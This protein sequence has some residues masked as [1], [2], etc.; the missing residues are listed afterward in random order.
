MASEDTTNSRRPATTRRFLSDESLA[1]VPAFHTPL[2]PRQYAEHISSYASRSSTQSLYPGTNFESLASFLLRAYRRHPSETLVSS[3]KTPVS[4]DHPFV[5][6][7]NLQHG[8]PGRKREFTTTQELIDYETPPIRESESANLL[9]LRGYPSAEWLN[10]LGS[11]FTIDPEFFRR[12]L[13]FQKSAASSPDLS[14]PAL[15]SAA[16]IMTRLRANTVAFR[17]DN[18][19]VPARRFQDDLDNLR[20]E[21]KQS[22]LNYLETLRHG[23]DIDVRMGESVVR[24]FCVL[25]RQYTIIE[26]D[27]SIY[28]EQLERGFFAVIWLDPS[29]DLFES[30]K[31]PWNS[32]SLRSPRWSVEY[33]PIIQPKPFSALRHPSLLPNTASQSEVRIPQS[34]A[35]LPLEYTR[36]LDTAL[37]G[38]DRFFVLGNIFYFAASSELLALNIIETSLSQEL[39]PDAILDQ[40]RPSIS[41]LLHTK[42]ILDRHISRLRENIAF[43]RKLQDVAPMH[44]VPPGRHD[45]TDR[46]ALVMSQAFESLL[47]RAQS[48]AGKC[49]RGMDIINTQASIRE[50]S[51]GI[52]QAEDMTRLTKLALPFIPLSLTTSFFGMNF[53]ELGS[54]ST[55]SIWVWLVT[56]AAVLMGTFTFLL[57]GQINVK[58][59]LLIL[60][61]KYQR[62]RDKFSV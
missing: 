39:E 24:E 44:L 32:G 13:D 3:S 29:K 58:Q 41:N 7:Y 54:A 11:K 53:K 21:A 56:S 49:D 22:F 43:L 47:E 2:T 14:L 4:D 57:W 51:K 48:L 45:K 8:V 46:S 28:L 42:I 27:M 26:Q 15:P 52:A 50:A 5:V 34:A 19:P 17:M 30:A 6:H 12:H 55:L 18:K 62:K 23:S 25:N 10:V 20:N 1:N 9:F 31:G 33:L 35:L 16:P 38:S 61:Q 60:R 59:Q 40:R 37:A 36:Y